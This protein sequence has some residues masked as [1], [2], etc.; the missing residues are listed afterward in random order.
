MT[1]GPTAYVSTALTG[2]DA[3]TREAITATVDVVKAVCAE[4]E[5]GFEVYFPG[6]HTDPVRDPHVEPDEVFRIDRDRVKS[7]DL[8][9]FALHAPS[10]GVGLELEMARASLLPVVFLIPDGV[11][12]SR[13]ARGVPAVKAEVA[14]TDAGML[15]ERLRTALV[16]LRPRV[17][18]RRARAAGGEG[19][20]VGAAIRELR[21][22]RRLSRE[23]L[24]AATGLTARGVALL[25][26]SPDRCS[27]PSLTQLRRLAAALGVRAGDLV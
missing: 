14:F 21:E 10:V 7:A 3:R 22:E 5:V 9:L 13:M 26:E 2:V 25:E 16:R 23:D 6:D 18:E 1:P 27:D 12:V 20:V 24:A 4:P 8:V 11:R 19:N 15:R 17:Q